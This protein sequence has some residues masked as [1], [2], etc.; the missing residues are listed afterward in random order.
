MTGQTFAVL[1]TAAS[2][3]MWRGAA[4]MALYALAGLA[5]VPWF[6]EG[7]TAMK[8]GALVVTFGYILGFIAAAAL[9]AGWRSGVAPGPRCAP[10]A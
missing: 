6:A 10:P 2:L 1:L 3:G 5:G 9:S 8:G 4:S 7:S